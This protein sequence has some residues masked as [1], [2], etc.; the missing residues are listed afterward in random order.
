MN[1][2]FEQI[3]T[4]LKPEAAYL[5]PESGQRGGFFVF[6]ME[7]SSQLVDVCEPFWFGL[8]ADVEITPVMSAEDL[9]KGFGR[10]G[11]ILQKYG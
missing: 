6:N 3:M 11:A 5:Y 7:D 8:G 10:L 9:T 4:D 2:F 1:K